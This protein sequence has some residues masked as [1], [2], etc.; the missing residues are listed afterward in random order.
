[1]LTWHRLRRKKRQC[2]HKALRRT[3]QHGTTSRV[4]QAHSAEAAGSYL[5]DLHVGAVLHT[6]QVFVASID[7]LVRLHHL[8]L[9]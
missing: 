3:L 2:Q 6:E 4:S 1:M 8:P 5:L 9:R 7:H